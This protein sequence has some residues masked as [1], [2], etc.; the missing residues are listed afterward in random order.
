M[1]ILLIFKTCN[2][3]SQP[4][5]R[6]PY[7][8]IAWYTF[9]RNWLLQASWRREPIMVEK[10][11]PNQALSWLEVHCV[12][13]VLVA[14]LTG[15]TCKLPFSL[16]WLACPQKWQLNTETLVITEAIS[17]Q[18]CTCGLTMCRTNHSTVLQLG[19]SS[20]R[21]CWSLFSWKCMLYNNVR[22]KTAPVTP[23]TSV[24]K[25]VKYAEKWPRLSPL[26]SSIA[27]YTQILFLWD[28]WYCAYVGL[29]LESHVVTQSTSC[30]SHQLSFS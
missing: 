17:M 27:N 5:A 13:L 1:L 7:T 28:L 12:T 6:V 15:I 19:C 26:T 4:T 22:Y 16:L 14:R 11:D 29:C 30:L 21:L 9:D 10:F 18:K 2:T 3:A 24:I 23:F 25:H 20:C 8:G